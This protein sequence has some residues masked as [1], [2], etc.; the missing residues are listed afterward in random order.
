LPWDRDEAL[1]VAGLYW[2]W[3]VR[4]G[5]E[6]GK[7]LGADYREIRFEEL[8]ANPREELSKLGEFI[9]HNLDYDRIQRAGIGSVSQ[10]NSSF[11]GESPG[12]F[13]PVDRWKAKMS[14]RAAPTKNLFRPVRSQALDENDSL[15]AVR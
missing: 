10:P 7:L 2:E 14:S 5:R 8:I 1:G 11:A 3:I 15:G 9:D 12:A 4:K 6:Q 13:N